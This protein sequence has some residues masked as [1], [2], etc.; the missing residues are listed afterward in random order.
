MRLD[1]NLNR[2]IR[3]SQ[4]LHNQ[5]CPHRLMR[6]I[7][8]DLLDCIHYCFVR[9]T[10]ILGSECEDLI[11]AISAGGLEHVVHIGEGLGDL[12]AEIGRT[13]DC[14]SVPFT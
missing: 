10:D 5:Q 13:F 9:E 11:P 1:I 6:R 2:H 3:K 12:L 8:P 4:L 14:L 7:L